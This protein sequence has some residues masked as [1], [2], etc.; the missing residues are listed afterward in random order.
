MEQVILPLS[1]TQNNTKS[2]IASIITY[3][4]AYLMD[5][6]LNV[7]GLLMCSTAKKNAN[8]ESDGQL[9]AEVL[10]HF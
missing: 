3:S 9:L 7:L 1:E 2:A 10:P 5:Y 8:D 6:G 4:L